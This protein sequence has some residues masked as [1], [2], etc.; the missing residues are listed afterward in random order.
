MKK[1][2]KGILFLAMVLSAVIVFPIGFICEVIE[3]G[4][5][6]GRRVSEEFYIHMVDGFKTW[7]N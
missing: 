5:A 2:F 6:T 4:W 3:M 1:V 7:K